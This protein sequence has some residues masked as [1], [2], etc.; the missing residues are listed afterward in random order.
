MNHLPPFRTEL[1]FAEF[2]FNAPHLLSSSD[3]ETMTVGELL[4]VAGESADTILGVSLGYSPS[5]GEESLR[6]A[7]AAKTRTLEAADV[8]VLSSP[9]EGLFLAA[10]ALDVESIVL[11]PAYDALKNLPAITKPWELVPS[12]SGWRLDFEA[13]EAL[14][15][16][17]T[18]LLV[19]NFPHNPTGFEPEPAEWE[20]LVG[21]TRERGI[22]LFSDEMY[23]GLS[24][25]GRSPLPSAVDLDEKALVLSGLSKAHG[26]PG[27]RGG[28][29]TS[30]DHAL[31]RR[32]HDLKFYTSICAPSPVERL[33]TLAVRYQERL[34]A[35]SRAVIER[36]IAVAEE[37][38]A[39]WSGRFIWRAPRAGSVALVEL[40]GEEGAES[41]CYRLA[42]E[43]GIVLLPASFLGFPD[44]YVRFGLGR[45]SFPKA[46][47]ALAALR[48]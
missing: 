17:Q 16:P 4:E 7:V 26:L 8:L 37:F 31:L 30:R 35:R 39:R 21:W 6:Q 45:E 14:A 19:V 42:R 29:L 34:F 2:E 5:W 9:I 27:L 33:A 23:R 41:Y 48:D 15:S 22:R 43:H 1:Y 13:L 46:L 18:G 24:R 32:I 10:Q 44:R 40:K 11:T 25:S 28:W 38:F 20:R 3:C 36:N 12:E 47:D